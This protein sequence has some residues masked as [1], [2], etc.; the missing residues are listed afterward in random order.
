MCDLWK[1][2]TNESV[3]SGDIPAQI[4][5]ALNHLPHVKHLKLYNSGS[6]FDERAIPEKDYERIAS[7]VKGFETLLVE[8]HPKLIG[9]KC[10][11][12]KNMLKPELQIAI[13]LETVHPEILALIN[14]KMTIEDFRESVSFLNNHG[15]LSRAFVLLKPPFMTESEGVYWAQMSIESAFNSGVE[16]CTIIPVRSG[17]GAMDILQDQGHFSPPDI[18][19]LETVT[20]YGIKINAGRVF[21]DLWD[22]EKFSRCSKCTD[23]RVARLVAMNLGQEIVPP[24]RCICDS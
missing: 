23:Q 13:G 20:E 14:K 7:L 16:C 2:T 4:E 11:T 17:N 9:E 19:S 6:F 10:L 8:S 21:A 12:F 18:R 3:A 1:N 24:V 15:I 5:W 22:I